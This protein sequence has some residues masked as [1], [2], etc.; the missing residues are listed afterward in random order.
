MASGSARDGDIDRLRRDHEDH[1]EPAV[2]RRPEL[3]VVDPAEGPHEAHDRRHRP[4]R[5]V[6]AR[7]ELAGQRP[8]HVPG[9]AAAGDV[10]DP[11]KVVAG[12]PER[13]PHGEDVPGV[14]P[15]RG[16]EHVADGRERVVRLG[17]QGRVA[18]GVAE[19]PGELLL[20]RPL[21][22]DVPLGEER[23]DEREAVR[24]E[25]GRRQAEDHVP[26]R[27]R[28]PVEDVR[29]LHD[30][31]ARPGEIERARLHEPGVLGG[32]AADERAAGLATAVG[33]AAD[34]GGHRLGVEPPDGDVVEEGERLGAG[35]DDVV[36][37]HRDE[38]DADRVPAP[39]GGREGGLR[40][41]AVRRR[42]DER[43]PIAGRDR[44]RSPEAAEPADDLD[45]PRGFDGGPHPLDGPVAGGDVDPGAGVGGPRR[46]PLPARSSS[47]TGRDRLL[48]QEL[49]V[50]DVVRAPAPGSARRSRRS[51]TARRAGRAR[52]G[53]RRSRGS[54]ACR[55]R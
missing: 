22:R 53:R 24:V 1:P 9:Q 4:A 21:E 8:G 20:V 34:E 46:A 47:A 29:A 5:G 17:R 36:G 18:P 37:A 27:G 54:R 11:A 42:H 2:E 26:G 13:R 38:I 50:L 15:R 35:A 40:P 52:R 49:P 33:D 3:D 12:G 14:D 39:E 43:L 51:R 31:D 23:A 19:R 16:Q 25:P 48:E 28:R 55:R 45:P 30:P 32:L 7:T 6:D 41:D 44:D 10:G